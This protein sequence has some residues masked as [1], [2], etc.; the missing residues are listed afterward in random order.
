MQASVTCN[1]L[2]SIHK[3]TVYGHLRRNQEQNY[4]NSSVFVPY[5]L[6]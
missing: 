2:G 3:G 1:F 6:H 4:S 5:T